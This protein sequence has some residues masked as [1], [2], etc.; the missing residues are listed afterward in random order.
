M[1]QQQT[2]PKSKWL[3]TTKIYISFILHVYT[4][5]QWAEDSAHHDYSE[6]QAA[7]SSSTWY[8]HVKFFSFW[9][10]IILTSIIFI[11][12]F[13]HLT[14]SSTKAGLA[15]ASSEC[16]WI[17]AYRVWGAGFAMEPYFFE[18]AI[19]LILTPHPTLIAS[20]VGN[21]IVLVIQTLPS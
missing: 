18:I 1:W 5:W 9:F 2:S 20:L 13:S 10:S 14:V 19:D 12:Y 7:R 15:S 3:K 17:L 16:V 11:S 21:T 6:T 4:G 8:H